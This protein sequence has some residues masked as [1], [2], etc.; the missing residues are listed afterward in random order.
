MNTGLEKAT[1]Q[2]SAEDFHYL[3]LQFQAANIC[4]SLFKFFQELSGK[5]TDIKNSVPFKLPDL[6]RKLP[7]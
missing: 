5:T 4:L 6:G 1:R 2:F 3:T 7:R